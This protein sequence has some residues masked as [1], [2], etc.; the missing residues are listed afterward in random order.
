VASAIRDI[1]SSGCSTSSCRV[2]ARSEGGLGIGLTLAKRL[3]ELHGGSITAKSDG[4]GRGSRF[5]VR[6]P[7]GTITTPRQ[8]AR[9]SR[10]S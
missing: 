1:W 8:A 3:V 4:P 5:T 10:P 9:R 7:A 2:S 6:L